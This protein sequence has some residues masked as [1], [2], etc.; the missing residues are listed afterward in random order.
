MIVA[1]MCTIP[2][3]KDTFQ[4]VV[5][6]ILYEQTT[7][8][9]QLHVWL[10]GYTQIEADFAQ[11]ARL[12]YHLEPTN[13]GPWIRYKVAD[14]LDDKSL[15]VTLD[16][17]MLYPADYI[18]QGLY[19]IN[20][21]N[22]KVVASYTGMVWD[23]FQTSFSYGVKRFQFMMEK[24]LHDVRQAALGGGG[25]SFFPSSVVRQVINLTLPG[26]RTNDDMMVGYILQKRHV[27]I[28]CCPKPV[29]WIREANTSRAPHALFRTNASIRQKTFAQLT[30][31]LGFDPT[32]GMLKEIKRQKN[33][34]LI[35]GDI[36]PPLPDSEVLDQIARQYCNPDSSV[37]ILAGTPASLEDEVQQYVDTPY[38]I[39]PVTYPEPGGRLNRFAL[40]RTWR[41]WR[42]LR[43]VQFN[44]VE[45]L[46]MINSRLQPTQT[47][48]LR[49]SDI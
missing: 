25:G 11:D 33:R 32:A 31:H 1:S 46:S 17:D 24:P 28:Y 15:L 2:E 16:D 5:R 13:P 18:A 9:D 36:C 41:R 3:R 48:D 49:Q 6:S 29:R 23:P 44:W 30:N 20:K 12:I 27:S 34:I 4:Q 43:S 45:R 35:L 22:D 10:N 37:H 8:V 47:I 38:F 42:V 40:V 26:F 7:P 14:D 39:H 21:Y 19:W